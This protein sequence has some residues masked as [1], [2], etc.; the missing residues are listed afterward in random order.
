[1]SDYPDPDDSFAWHE[2]H[3][4]ASN[5]LRR[6]IG[7]LVNDLTDARRSRT[8][9]KLE[10]RRRYLRA[11]FALVEGTLGGIR[12]IALSDI[13]RKRTA[14]SEAEIAVLTGHAFE[15]D[16]KGK[17]RGR[18]VTYQVSSYVRFMLPILARIYR[19]DFDL[20]VGGS[21]WRSFEAA[22]LLRNRVTHPRS[23]VDLIISDTEMATAKEG[24]GW[25][26]T[27]MGRITEG[28]VQGLD[29]R[30][31]RLTERRTKLDSQGEND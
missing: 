18:P 21:G 11:G 3:E 22:R 8:G 25:F 4:K 30:L 5:D 6:I 9:R 31:A 19:V 26:L 2:D 27:E 28:I 1:L 12:G 13:H 7:V 29:E 15:L 16:R 14:F 17:T 23:S 24:I 10:R 20:D